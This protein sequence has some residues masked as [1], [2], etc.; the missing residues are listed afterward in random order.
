MKTKIKEALQQGHKNLGISEEVFERVA[1]S[2]ETFITDES[3]IEEW[4]KSETTLAMLKSYQSMAD[5]IRGLE[6]KINPNPDKPKP[7]DG[8]GNNKPESKQDPADIAKL[9]AE[10]VANAIKP[11]SEDLGK[12]K[13]EQLAKSAFTTAEQTFKSN[14]YV[15]KYTDEATEAWER[16][17]ELYEAT[18]KTWTAEELGQ[19]AMAYFNK[20]V[21]RKGVDTSK[22]FDG[23]GDNKPNTDFSE[24]I[25]LLKAQGIELPE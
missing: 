1:A 10:A 22:P 13:A 2:V 5:K 20:S 11:L 18:G 9:I 14:D 25:A 17:N 23:G 24:H 19:K 21:S 3:K 15:K 6:A 16:A 8:D 12:F 7:S 4:V